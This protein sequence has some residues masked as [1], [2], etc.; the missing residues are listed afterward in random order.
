MTFRFIYFYFALITIAVILLLTG[1]SFSWNS[2][3][4]LLIS[5]IIIYPIIKFYQTSIARWVKITMIVLL[6]SLIGLIVYYVL[7]FLAFASGD[8]KIIEKWQTKGYTMVLERRLDWAGPSYYKFVL[9]QEKLFGL[10][11]KKI[12]DKSPETGVDFTCNITFSKTDFRNFSIE[13]DTCKNTI[14]VSN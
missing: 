8:V 6:F 9:H 4:Y 14:K 13:Y 10:F 12:G 2:I 1:Y 7:P 11:N 5:I 3:N